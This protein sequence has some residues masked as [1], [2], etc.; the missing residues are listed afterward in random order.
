MYSLLIFINFLI[1][2]YISYKI[3]KY[4]LKPNPNLFLENKNDHLITL[5]NINF[6]DKNHK[7]IKRVPQNPQKIN[8]EININSFKQLDF[9]FYT[10]AYE[11]FIIYYIYNNKLYKWIER[12]N[13]T[14]LTFPFYKK[15]E[16]QNFVF[17]NKITKIY[18]DN[19]LIRDLD[20]NIIPF[21]GPNY[22][23]YNDLNYK[24][25]AKQILNYFNIEYNE[26]SIFELQDK[27]E[28]IFK[29]NIEDKLIWNPKLN[30]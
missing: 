24:I 25:T 5:N 27:F 8:L 13:N 14:K 28:N 2:G 3:F 29:F 26:N 30:L 6:Y 11:Y 16:Y 19:K 10:I 17:I 7:L 15:E 21:L 4:Y 12:D 1:F 9:S 23:F 18:L 20:K 22:N